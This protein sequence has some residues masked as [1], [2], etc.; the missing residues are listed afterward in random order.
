MK[1]IEWFARGTVRCR[2]DG[3]GKVKVVGR[4]GTGLIGG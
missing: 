1:Q 3:S 2:N 4:S